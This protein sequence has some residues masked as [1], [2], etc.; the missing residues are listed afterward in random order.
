[1]AGGRRVG[2]G[3]CGGWSCIEATG[4][5]EFVGRLRRAWDDGDAVFPLDP[6]LPQRVADE[7]VAA[8]VPNEPVEEGDA[9]VVAT[10]GTTGAPRGVVLTHDAVL[11][12]A[13]ATSAGLGV[14]P[15][16]D[17]WLACLPLAHVGGLAVVTRALLT[18]TRLVVHARFDAARVT[19]S[20]G[21]EGVTLVSL[22]PTMLRRI[23]PTPFRRILLGGSAPPPDRPP[24]VIATYGMTETGSGVVYDGAPLDGVEVRVGPGPAGAD[25]IFVRGPMLLRAYRDGVD[26]KT[27]DGWLPT[28]DLGEWD[29]DAGRLRVFGRGGDLIITG[30]ANVWPAAVEAVLS[31]HPKVDA[32]RIVG[33]DDPEW[34]QRVVAQVVPA[35]PADPPSLDDLRR[36][37]REHLAPWAAPKQL[38]LVDAAA[39]PRTAIGKA[40]RANSRIT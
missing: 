36:L 4:D 21:A 13:R 3:G 19:N 18:G 14:D 6:R 30:G 1:M 38:D 39:L 5:E 33:R 16:A 11:A 31:G 20:V 9:L 32:V 12:S 34:G 15:A 22:V 27:A 35:D 28:G 23:D 7:L 25:E 17:A 37:A 40:G 26:P 29:Q 10:S 2:S 24:N 8:M